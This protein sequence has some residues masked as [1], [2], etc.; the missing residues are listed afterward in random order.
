MTEHLEAV[1]R[2]ISKG[3]APYDYECIQQVAEAFAAGAVSPAERP[4]ACKHDE[5]VSII[6]FRS[7]LDECTQA[8]FDGH[9]AQVCR[10]GRV[11]LT[12]LSPLFHK[13]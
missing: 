1:V 5:V 13:S 6:E 11:P 8:A 3:I 7:R 9:P 2:V 4:K 10:H 12:R